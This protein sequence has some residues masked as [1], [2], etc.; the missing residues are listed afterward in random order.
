VEHPVTEMVTGVDIVKEQLLL[1]L[2]QPMRI[3]PE[4]IRPRGAAIEARILAEDS[5]AGFLPFHR[6]GTLPERT[7]ARGSGSTRRSTRA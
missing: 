3:F 4:E 5:Q 1:A 2:G 6:S 7:R